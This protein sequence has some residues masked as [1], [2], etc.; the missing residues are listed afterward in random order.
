MIPLSIP[1]ISGNEWQYVKDC[2][3]TG[4]ISSVGSYVN[5]FEEKIAE[6][7]G[8]KYAV[9]AMNGT[10]A[11]HL[12]MQLAGV[13]RDDYVIVPDITFIASCN[14]V[15]YLGAEPLLIDVDKFT[16]QMDLN[17]LELYL[18]E[19]TILMSSKVGDGT[20]II[21]SHIKTSGRRIGAILPVHVLGNMVDMDRLSAICSKYHIPMVEDSTEALGST[22]KGKHAGTFGIFGTSSFNGNK[23]ISTGGGGMIFTNDENLAK[24]AKHLTTQAKTDPFEYDH[25]EIGYNYRLVNIL[26]AVG[27]A[28]IEQL[29]G[30]LKRKKEIDK[31][32]R[33]SLENENL[34]FQKVGENVEPNNWLHTMWVDQQRPMIAH[35]LE[36][37]VQCRPFW[38]PMHQLKMFKDCLFI[39]EDQISGQVY[40]HCI[41]IPSSTNLTDAQVEEVVKVVRGFSS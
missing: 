32:Y 8:A 16:W 3:D 2:L 4:W 30:F 24:K 12:S 31:Y 14:A 33:E 25:D 7:T 28:Q 36:H 1:N 17:L 13:K 5:A 39:S 34:R 35:L 9:A 40:N 20:E 37:G 21:R 27:V 11:L 23:I 29:P 19:N 41:S 38:V 10:A 26:A 22:F 6:F 18:E 15:S